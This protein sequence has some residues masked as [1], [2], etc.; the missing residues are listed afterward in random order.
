[1]NHRGRLRASHSHHKARSAHWVAPH[2]AVDTLLPRWVINVDWATSEL[3]PVISRQRTLRGYRGMSVWCQY[4]K[5]RP[6][7]SNRWCCETGIAKARTVERRRVI[8][9]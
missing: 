1:M 7:R 5:S 2:I 8:L 4:R 9:E 6:T 3:G